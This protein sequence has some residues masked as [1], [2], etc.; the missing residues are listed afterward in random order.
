[1]NSNQFSKNSFSV[2][3]QF[4]SQQKW[5]APFATLDQTHAR[6]RISL[7]KPIFHT[8]L[9][10]WIMYVRLAKPDRMYICCNDDRQG[11]IEAGW[12]AANHDSIPE[13]CR[14]D[15]AEEQMRATSNSPSMDTWLRKNMILCHEFTWWLHETESNN[16]VHQLKLYQ[17]LIVLLAQFLSEVTHLSIFFI[18]HLTRMDKQ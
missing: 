15:D 3:P 2:L 17:T 11:Q 16:V 4:T 13:F 10:G 1:M 6:S 14:D 5:H 9:S 8:H 7:V 18:L 12:G